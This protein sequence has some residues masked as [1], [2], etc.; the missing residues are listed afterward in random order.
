MDVGR[1]DAGQFILDATVGITGDQR[2]LQFREPPDYEW[3]GD[4]NGDSVY[5]VTLVAD[6]TKGG[7]AKRGGNRVRG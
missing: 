3:P 5:K 7:V 1:D 6:D 2:Q 4:A